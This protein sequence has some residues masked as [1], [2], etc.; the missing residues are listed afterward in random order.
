MVAADMFVLEE[1]TGAV[2]EA[3]QP[4]WGGQPAKLSECAPLFHA[5]FELRGAGAVLH[6]HAL[7]SV[8]VTLMDEDATEF[9]GAAVRSRVAP[10]R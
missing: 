8:L 1:A 2:L 3:P 7:E 6:S 9:R 10:R 5:A 4:G